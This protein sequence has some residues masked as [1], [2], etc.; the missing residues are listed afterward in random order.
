IES[1]RLI[2]Y[3]IANLISKV[4]GYSYIYHKRNEL[5]DAP[6]IK[7]YIQQNKLFTVPQTYRNIKALRLNG[8]LHITQQQV[9]Y[10]CKHLGL[11]E[12]KMAEDQVESVI[13]YLSQQEQIT[14]IVVD[15]T[16]KMNRLSYLFLKPE[17]E[18]KRTSVLSSWFNLIK[19]RGINYVQTLLTDKNFAHIA[20]ARK[21]WP[22]IRIQL[23]YWHVLHAVKK[24][25]T[26]TGIICPMY[27]ASEAHAICSVIDPTWELDLNNDMRD[28]FTYNNARLDLL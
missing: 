4:D 25:L 21:T 22:Q 8:Y 27:S 13:R 12:Y 3:Q 18:Q 5:Q 7:E 20:S 19:E 2:A 23:C 10:W 28:K 14:T 11:N 17:Q 24:K 16:Y 15:A 9:Y 6:E 1:D 26:S